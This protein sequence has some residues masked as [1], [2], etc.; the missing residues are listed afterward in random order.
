MATMV[1]RYV[2]VQIPR[3]SELANWE[4]RMPGFGA[5][6]FSRPVLAFAAAAG[7]CFAVPAPQSA[8]AD[9]MSSSPTI[10][11]DQQAPGLATASGVAATAVVRP[12]PPENFDFARASDAELA[13]YGLPQRPDKV[14][15][16]TAFAFWLKMMSASKN[17][18]A[19]VFQET[20][21]FHGIPKG[22]K[23]GAAKGAVVG[24]EITGPSAAPALGAA[25]PLNVNASS[26]N[27]SGFADYE[28]TAP[29]LGNHSYMF[30]EWIVPTAQQAFG[31][32]TGSWDY[33]SQ[34]VGFDGFAS[35]DVLQ[36][37]TEADAFC[38]SASTSQFYAFWFE[39]YP[40]SST[41]ITNFKVHPG[42]LIEIW[43]TYATSAPQGNVYAVN[44]T[45]NVAVAV[46]FSPPPGTA[47]AGTS[48]E[49]IVEAPSVGGSQAALTNYTVSPWNYAF[50][51]S[52]VTGLYDLPNYTPT[53]TP[54][55][56]TMVNAGSVAISTCA[57]SWPYAIWCTPAGPAR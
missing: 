26:T 57:S 4:I 36:A 25:A 11:A 32:C 17:R 34:W 56:I 49:W 24:S 31:A 40:F 30:A 48:A 18:V 47:L 39:W 35:N 16:P 38:Q 55:S 29:Y 6:L 52:S 28:P 5:P 13:A 9:A 8:F 14:K 12:A 19:P 22:V 51:Y 50:A 46:G 33:S 53:G 7:L 21:V 15:H 45:T 43:L 41:R 23:I 1:F 20:N 2:I 27:W 10:A 3:Q 42:D 37:G 54:Y 44:L